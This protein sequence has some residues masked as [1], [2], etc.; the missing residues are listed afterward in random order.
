M[1]ADYERCTN[2]RRSGSASF[3]RLGS[4]GRPVTLFHR[5]V[6]WRKQQSGTP[7]LTPT[8]VPTGSGLTPLKAGVYLLTLS[9]PDVDNG[10]P[11]KHL[12]IVATANITLK[13]SK[14]NATAWVTDM[15]SG[16][17]IPNVPV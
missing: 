7:A 16:Q 2:Y 11:L 4:R 10:I 12:M 13:V 15:Q 9:T 8:D 17:P 14:T 5:R 3:D 6:G 1:V